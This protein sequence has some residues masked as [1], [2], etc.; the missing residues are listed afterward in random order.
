MLARRVSADQTPLPRRPL[1]LSLRLDVSISLSR[2]LLVR[3]ELHGLRT[4]GV[5]FEGTWFMT[6]RGAA[7]LVGRPLLLERHGRHGM[8]LRSSWQA[9]QEVV[10]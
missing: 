4:E 8:S 1:V 5:V 3:E 2:S 10:A 7:W 9:F 6:T